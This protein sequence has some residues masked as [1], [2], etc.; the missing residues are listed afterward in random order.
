VK[1]H[2][3]GPLNPATDQIGQKYFNGVD[4]IKRKTEYAKEM[5][6]GGVMIWEVGQDNFIN[7][8]AAFFC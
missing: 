3:K 7:A 5:K 2:A 1:I 6:C 4:M 8:L